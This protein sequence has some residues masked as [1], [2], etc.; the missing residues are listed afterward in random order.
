MFYEYA[1]MKRMMMNK[2]KFNIAWRG[3]CNAETEGE[4]CS[5]HEGLKCR[6]GQQANRECPETLGAFICGGLLC[7]NCLS[8]NGL[9]FM[10]HQHF[11]ANDVPVSKEIW[12]FRKVG[13]TKFENYKV[14]DS[15]ELAKRVLSQVIEWLDKKTF[16]VQHQSSDRATLTYAIGNLHTQSISFEVVSAI[17]LTDKYWDQIECHHDKCAYVNLG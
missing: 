6:C 8:V 14:C 13:E 12:I 7:E 5:I 10:N 16:T 2:C 4:F 3:Y 17:L 15:E 9:G 1:Q 11:P